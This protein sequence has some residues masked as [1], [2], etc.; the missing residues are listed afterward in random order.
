MKVTIEDKIILNNPAIRKG[1]SPFINPDTLTWWEWD[2]DANEYYDTQQV[3]FWNP[4]EEQA[5]EAIDAWLDA[6]PEATTTVQDNTISTSK[7]IDEAVTQDKISLD[8]IPWIYK[9]HVIPEMYGAAGNGTTDDSA[10]FQSCIDSGR[11]IY[12]PNRTYY[13]AS[14]ITLRSNLTIICDGILKPKMFKDVVVDGEHKQ[15]YNTIITADNCKNIYIRGLTIQ[16]NYTYGVPSDAWTMV[17]EIT[18]SYTLVIFRDCDNVCLENT[19]I[20]QVQLVRPYG[21]TYA[22]KASSLYSNIGVNPVKFNKCTRLKL[23]SFNYTNSAGE[24]IV[25]SESEH[26]EIKDFYTDFIGISLLDIVYSSY[27]KLDGFSCVSTTANGLNIHSQHV[28]VKNAVFR[29]TRVDL[30]NEYNANGIPGYSNYQVNDV[31]ISDSYFYDSYITSVIGKQD[32]IYTVLKGIKIHDCRCE[33]YSIGFASFVR[34]G[35]ANKYEDIE[36]YNNYIYLEAHS[37]STAGASRI[38]HIL[39]SR[40]DNVWIHDNYFEDEN[41][42]SM[43]TVT[44][45]GVLVVWD[46]SDK[47][48]KIVF[49]RNTLKC[50][51]LA[52]INTPNG[53]ESVIIRDNN[54]ELKAGIRQRGGKIDDLT[55]E[56]N[57]ISF[58]TTPFAIG[59]ATG[60][61]FHFDEYGCGND[62]LHILNNKVTGCGLI[63][64]RQSVL[65]ETIIPVKNAEICGN[66]TTIIRQT[67]YSSCRIYNTII[68][69]LIF[70]N[71][72]ENKA[73][74]IETTGIGLMQLLTAIVKNNICLENLIVSMS[75][76]VTENDQAIVR[77]NQCRTLQYTGNDVPTEYIYNNGEL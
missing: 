35:N 53:C 71:N 40:C 57:V 15:A 59:R 67:G 14:P 30:S 10:A 7:L 47:I 74:N 4:T 42:D 60:F 46:G 1:Y 61:L 45:N 62:N 44:N 49:E 48:G 66:M 50:I 37:V 22:D 16:G 73:E 52:T 24:A 41:D 33:Y 55:I 39:L 63:D 72:I 29:N 38:Q 11:P 9:D 21:Y 17:P 28:I 2:Q 12:I 36:I 75:E 20:D 8:F 43:E 76:R 64:I 32:V 65:D 18:E 3:Y 13:I 58:V 34:F 77:D 54:C 25:V 27:V 70:C 6:H 68:G 31:D 5:K 56:G 26:V 51:N 19:T 69:R 23:Q